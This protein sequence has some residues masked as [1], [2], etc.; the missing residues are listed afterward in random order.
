ML[1]TDRLK[2]LACAA[3]DAKSSEIIDLAKD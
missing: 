1:S 3:I 2:E